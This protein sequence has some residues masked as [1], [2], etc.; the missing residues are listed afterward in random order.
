MS[1]KIIFTFLLWKGTFTGSRD[2]HVDIFSGEGT[3]QPTRAFTACWSV[4]EPSLT[5]F[6]K[7]A[8]TEKMTS[9]DVRR[10]SGEQNSYTFIG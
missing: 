8:G 5:L 7:A 10:E 9:P 6:S 1:Y 2:S 3:I 4:A